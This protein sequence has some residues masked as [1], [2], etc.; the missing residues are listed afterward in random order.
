MTDLMDISAGQCEIAFLQL[1]GNSTDSTTN[2]T[3]TLTVASGANDFKLLASSLKR[4]K[5]LTLKMQANR[6]RIIGCRFV[7]PSPTTTIGR[8]VLLDGSDH[9]MSDCYVVS[10][11]VTTAVLEL[12][13][14]SIQVTNC[15]ITGVSTSVCNTL[16][17]GQR[18]LLTGCLFDTAGAGPM[19]TVSGPRVT[20]ANSNFFIQTAPSSPQQVCTDATNTNAIILKV[21]GCTSE[22]TMSETWSAFIDLGST[23]PDTI[24]VDDNNIGGCDL[25]YGHSARPSGLGQNIFAGN[26]IRK[27]RYVELLRGDV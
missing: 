12:L 27:G 24:V 2:A 21:L 15:H 26:A 19:I 3:D 9:V 20:I 13:R 16:A 23:A 25:I 1:D 18:I 11:G 7:Q 22:V 14:T 6:A 8:N 5:T 17:D 4:G 10:G